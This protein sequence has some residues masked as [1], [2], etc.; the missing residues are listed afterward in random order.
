MLNV[1]GRL[2][3][4]PKAFHQS[5]GEPSG[6]MAVSMTLEREFEEELLGRDDLDQLAS[7]GGSHQVAVGQAAP[8]KCLVRACLPRSTATSERGGRASRSSWNP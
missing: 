7:S 4:I 1:T 6:E 8:T 5:A 2:A 3:T